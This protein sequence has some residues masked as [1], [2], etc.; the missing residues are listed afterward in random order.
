MR[1]ASLLNCNEESDIVNQ[2]EEQFN[3]TNNPN[4]TEKEM[5]INENQ[6]RRNLLQELGCPLYKIGA[7]PSNNGTDKCYKCKTLVHTLPECSAHQPND[8]EI[9]ICY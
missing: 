5:N 4:E 7:L 6:H 8:D 3:N 2:S 1:G 9:R